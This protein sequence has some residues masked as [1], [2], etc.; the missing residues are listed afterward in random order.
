M[1]RCI[2][3]CSAWD[4]CGID[5]DV[6]SGRVDFLDQGVNFV[7]A[8]RAELVNF[9]VPLRCESIAVCDLSYAI[10]VWCRVC[11]VVGHDVYSASR[12]NVA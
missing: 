7:A 8:G 11:V 12:D 1:C 3:V 2:H 5:Q 9:Q 10:G 4:G 6:K